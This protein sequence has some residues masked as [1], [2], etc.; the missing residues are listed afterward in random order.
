MGDGPALAKVSAQLTL[1]RG[2]DQSCSEEHQAALAAFK[3]GPSDPGKQGLTITLAPPHA[4]YNRGIMDKLLEQGRAAQA[5]V[6][7]QVGA[8]F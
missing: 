6:G 3:A 8:A 4:R 5:V 1:L 7:A 2:L